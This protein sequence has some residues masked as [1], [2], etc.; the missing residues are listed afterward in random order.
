MAYSKTLIIREQLV[1]TRNLYFTPV[2]PINIRKQKD[3]KHRQ[4]SW[5]RGNLTKLLGELYWC[6][7]YREY[8]GTISVKECI[9][10]SHDPAVLLLSVSPME[11]ATQVCKATWT[12]MFPGAVCWQ[13]DQ[14]KL[15]PT[16]DPKRGHAL[17]KLTFHSAC[18]LTDA[19]FPQWNEKGSNKIRRCIPS[20]WRRP[21][22]KTAMPLCITRSR[23][24]ILD[25]IWRHPKCYQW[26]SG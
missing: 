22:K 23:R 26:E 4:V 25:M 16:Q 11:T 17:I 21:Q 13:W 5:D 6:D 9:W 20:T 10:L 3:T 12:G 2:R 19:P 1:K 8:S 18:L 24:E 15:S 7:H 14:G